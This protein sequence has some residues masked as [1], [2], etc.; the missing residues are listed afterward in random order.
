MKNEHFPYRFPLSNADLAEI[1]R[2]AARER[3][4][5]RQRVFSGFG[6]WLRG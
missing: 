1:H 3:A 4:L 2:R 5:A 6:R